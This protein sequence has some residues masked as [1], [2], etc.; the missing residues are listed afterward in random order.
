MGTGRA[1]VA[2]LADGFTVPVQALAKRL[3]IEEDVQFEEFQVCGMR[4]W[5]R[6]RGVPWGVV[7]GV[8]YGW[9]AGPPGRAAI[10]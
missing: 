2:V 6:G 4:E 10:L 1:P 5:P 9:A 8:W 3:H 7:C